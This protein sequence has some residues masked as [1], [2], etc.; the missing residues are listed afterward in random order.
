MTSE[1]SE[2]NLEGKQGRSPEMQEVIFCQL[3]TLMPLALSHLIVL[4]LIKAF[5]RTVLLIA[6]VRYFVIFSFP[7]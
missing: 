6:A 4:Y 3:V 2:G 7:G 1:V 5:I